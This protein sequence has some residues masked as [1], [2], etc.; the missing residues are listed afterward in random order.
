MEQACLAVEGAVELPSSAPQIRITAGVGSAGQKTW[1]LRRPVTLLGSKRPSHI[2]LHDRGVCAAHCAIVNTGT[3]V[4][5]FDLHTTGGTFRGKEQVQLTALQDGD[6]IKLGDS[7]VQV[8]IRLPTSGADDS[9]AGMEYSDPTSM[10][11]PATLSLI[12]TETRWT[13]EKAVAMIGRNDHA[14]IR[15]DHDEVS[16]R[17]ALLF[18]LGKGVAVFDL[19]SRA[20]VWV[21]GQRREISKVADGDRVTVGPFGL[22]LRIHDRAA[23]LGEAKA[24]VPGDAVARN[25]QEAA[26]QVAAPPA[27]RILKN[28]PIAPPPGSLGGAA[29]PPTSGATP[30]GERNDPLQTNIAD[31]WERLNQ[32]RSQ[33]RND[34][35]AITEQQSSLSAREAQIEARDAAFRG[36]LHD[37]TRFNEQIV[38][39]EKQLAERAAKVQ[40][41]ADLLGSRQKEFL[42]RQLE[43]QKKEEELHRREQALNQRWSRMQSTVCPHCQKP[44]T[45]GSG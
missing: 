19:G 43:I 10:T 20:G 12:H 17:H 16:S 32:W 41:D 3:D 18:R 14:A 21:N 27:A 38:E 29:E 36:Q 8:A 7:T 28:E 22:H 24:A 45:I 44:V 31:A 30:S 5:L 23:T 1:N 42:D 15:L 25:N 2:V 37:I 26:A 33:L 11:N 9:G 4:L 40:A 39:R 13:I 6:V 35:A 34:A